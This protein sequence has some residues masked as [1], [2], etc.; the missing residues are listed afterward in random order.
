MA[1]R[2]R[3]ETAAEVSERLAVPIGWIYRR[4]SRG[5]P[6]PLPFVKVGK[7]LRFRSSE[8]EHWLEEHRG[9]AEV[10]RELRVS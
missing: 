10:V 7:F 2:E 5:H 1:A 4:T 8:I 6:D 3:L 9:D